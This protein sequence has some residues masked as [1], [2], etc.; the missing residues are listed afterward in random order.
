MR[1]TSNPR[2]Q[3]WEFTTGNHGKSGYAER[4]A[5]LKPVGR[6]GDDSLEKGVGLR[7]GSV[8]LDWLLVPRDPRGIVLLCG[9]VASAAFG[10]I[11]LLS[12]PGDP[13]GW[14]YI[15][16][17]V[18]GYFFIQTRGLTT[19]LWLVFAAGGAAVVLAGEASGWV[20]CVLGLALAAVALTRLPAEYRQPT[21]LA[22]GTMSSGV[23]LAPSAGAPTS[24]KIEDSPAGT[25]AIAEVSLNGA[26]PNGATDA[27][28][29]SVPATTNAVEV[30][31]FALGHFLVEADGTDVSRGLEPRLEFLFCYLLARTVGGLDGAAD[32]TALAEEIAP[33]IG[34]A[35]QRDRL[36]KQLYD[37]QSLHPVLARLVQV[38]RSRVSLD[39]QGVDFDVNRLLEISRIVAGPDSLI[40]TQLA[41]RVR[42][43]LAKSDGEFL[44]G[45]SE[46]EHQVTGGRGSAAAEVV[47]QA[48]MMIAGARADLALAVG[49][50]DI[51]AG[52]AQ[53]AIVYMTQALKLSPQRQ[54]LARALVAAYL[55][56]GQV[57]LARDARREFDLIEEN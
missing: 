53:R 50:Y 37:L 56:T 14:A 40:D 20:E 23:V 30:R 11:A 39:L 18:M 12:P 27:H 8:L 47:E 15:G 34:P 21:A 16:V 25:S 29:R 42:G 43:V 33:G 35:S 10:I 7:E 2:H 41:N 26:S 1:P 45:F 17:A 28:I 9:Y 3:P 38:N 46:L 57:K 4:R 36:R 6:K 49:R 55:Q 48:R 32:R 5:G 44:A 19:F 13:I 54:D 22:V 52:H 24:G 51:A 31:I